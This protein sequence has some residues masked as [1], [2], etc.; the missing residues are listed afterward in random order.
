M[1]LLW[2]AINMDNATFHLSVK[3]CRTSRSMQVD[4]IACF[5]EAMAWLWLPAGIITDIVTFQRS[6]SV[7]V[8]MLQILLGHVGRI[9]FCKWNLPSK[10]WWASPGSAPIW[11]GRR[12][13]ASRPWLPTWP[14]TFTAASPLTSTSAFRI[15]SW[16]YLTASS[17]C[18]SM[19]PIPRPPCGWWCQKTW[20][21]GGNRHQNHHQLHPGCAKMAMGHDDMSCAAIWKKDFHTSRSLQGQLIQCFSEVIARL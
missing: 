5:F 2:D 16:S 20:H 10:T 7:A 11:L 13:C 4:F 17:C 19:P 12:S 1:P 21:P 15:C 18:R 8:S 3:T 6:N 9:S 14:R